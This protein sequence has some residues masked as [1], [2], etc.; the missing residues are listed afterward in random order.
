[1]FLPFRVLVQPD[2]ITPVT[3]AKPHILQPN[4]TTPPSAFAPTMRAAR[5]TDY[6][7]DND[8]DAVLSVVDDQHTPNLQTDKPPAGFTHPM[9]VRVLSVS[10]APGDARVMS[11]KTRE[12]QGPPSLPYTPGGDVCGVVVA[13]PDEENGKKCRYMVGDRIAARFMNKPMGML[14]EYALVNTDVCDVVPP[15]ISSDQAA[16]LVSSGTVAVILADAINEGDRVLILGAGGGVGSHL[17]QLVR[18]R[19]A[20]YVV[21]VGRDTER[22]KQKPLCCDDAVDYT[23]SNPFDTKEWKEDPFDVVFDLG[24]GGW[25]ALLNQSSR[26]SS[27]VK[28]SSKGGKFLTLT[29]D[30]PLFE[31]HS[32]WKILK[33]FLFPAL[34]RAIYTRVG[35]SRSYLPKYSY[36]MALPSSSDVVTRTLALA[37]EEKLVPVI[38][39][40]GPFPFTTEG[41]RDAFRLQSSYHAKGKVVIKVAD[42]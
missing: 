25:P 22:L 20:S 19:G 31:A 15:N 10:L 39:C 12:L 23:Q 37:A 24:S 27:I 29:P 32:I 8:Y 33:I 18:L 28:P 40:S 26:K 4:M 30:T 9:L 1:M 2:T 13:V 38:D 16:A 35:F 5:C 21:G 41:V 11:G 17:C 34:W 42:V 14:A 3:T 6:T 36:K 7:P